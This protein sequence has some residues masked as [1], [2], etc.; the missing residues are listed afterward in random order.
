[1]ARKPT[2]TSRLMKD[3][4]RLIDDPVPYIVAEPNP[5]NVL[6]WRVKKLANR[7]SNLLLLYFCRHYVVSGPENSPYLGGYYHG[8]LIFPPD[9]PFKPPAVYMVT[10]NG[11]FNTNKRLCLSISDFHPDTWNPAWSVSSILVGLLSFMLEDTPTLGSFVSSLRVKRI[12]AMESALFN[13]KNDTF[14]EL[15]PSLS[16]QMFEK[17]N[18]K[19]KRLLRDDLL[20]RKCSL[21]MFPELE[22]LTEVT[23]TD[24]CDNAAGGSEGDSAAAQSLRDNSAANNP[25]NAQ[26]SK[27]ST[28]I[29]IL[30]VIVSGLLMNYVL[31]SIN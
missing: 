5:R 6:E 30:A 12:L 18:D 1:M 24:N 2:A 10:P 8:Y 23:R 29:F 16:K 3:Y 15:F 4:S 26:N 14:R 28:N 31:K 19:Q 13:L 22:T 17:L 21:E 9:Y 20:K 11:R 27:L 7:I 25:N